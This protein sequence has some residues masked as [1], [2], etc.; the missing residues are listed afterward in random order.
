M[1]KPLTP[2]ITAWLKQAAAAGVAEPQVLCNLLERV[3][4]LEARPIPGSVE[5]AAPVA[6]DQE[7]CNAYN[8]A[9]GHSFGPA[10]LRAVYDLGRQHGAATLL[11]RLSAPAQEVGK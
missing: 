3:E 9:P 8:N 7:L 11:Q 5:L 1:S 2:E 6:T 10:H 4:A